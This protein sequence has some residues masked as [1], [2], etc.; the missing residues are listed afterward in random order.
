M[1]RASNLAGFTTS[2][3][4]TEDISAGIITAS[5]FSGGGLGVGIGTDTTGSIGFAVTSLNF[6]GAGNTFA[7]D[8]ATNTVDISI[9]GSGGGGGGAIGISSNSMTDYV[10]TGVTHVNFV[11]MAVT[12]VGLTTAV[13]T[14]AKDLTIA[15]RSGGYITINIIG[16]G[17]EIR[18]RNGS[19]VEVPA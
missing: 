2:L 11:G 9:S 10:G 5:H 14:V 4:T 17:L 13:V 1:T 15:P 19:V 18:L 8:A 7:Y 16:A 12:A 3:S 6:I